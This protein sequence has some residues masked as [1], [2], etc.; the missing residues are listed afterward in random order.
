MNN[1]NV[2]DVIDRSRL[3]P[4]QIL[5]VTLC[6][7][8]MI[9]DGFDVQAM[10]YVAPA[11]IKE[12]QIQPTALGPIFGAGLLGIMVGSLGLSIVA[13]KIGRRPVLIGAMLFLAMGMFATTYAS[14]I[15]H[16]IA[17]RFITGLAMGAIVPNAMA[18]AGEFSPLKVRV[19]LMMT[20]SS[21]FIIGGAI[22][23]FIS[24]ALI[25][26]FGWQSVFYAGAIAPLVVAAVMY[27][28]MPESLQFLVLRGKQLTKVRASLNRIDP[29]ARIGADSGFTLPEPG[30]KGMP[31]ANLFR[32]GM[33]TGTMLLWVINFMNLLCAYFLANWLPV[34]MTGAGHSPSQA[35]LA[36]TM[37]WVGG[38]VGNLLLGWFVDR[39]G[40]GP[41]LTVTFLVG[42][43]AIA[44]IGQVAGSLIAA[45]MV[46][47]MAGFCVLGAQSGL[48]ALSPTYYP[49]SVRSTGT[50]WASGIG[51]FG[52]IFGPVV[53]GELM[54]LNWST[55]ELFQIAA[56][57][58]AIAVLAML[59]FWRLVRL[60][61]HGRDDLRGRAPINHLEKLEPARSGGG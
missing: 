53:G 25:P 55:G 9:M 21:G 30:T 10:G 45:F 8:C 12:W 4:L 29:Q 46:V 28:A 38:I 18:L 61:K 27:F 59:A 60:T 52:S 39:R 49:V 37:F 42:A 43:I 34:V 31:V 35:V 6:G 41:V 26:A 54:R 36:G 44:L 40:F 5:V 58:A 47:A 11:L 7:I 17:L 3:H 32:D 56:V 19:T 33:A 1:I 20:V 50:G 23:G 2:A 14:S 16:L 24:A 22:G 13:D 15:N 51:R 57:P 48:N